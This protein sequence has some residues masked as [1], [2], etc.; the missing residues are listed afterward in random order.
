MTEAPELSG[1]QSRGGLLAALFALPA[2]L[3]VV[4]A[5]SGPIVSGDLF[6]HLSTGHWILDN[7]ALPETDP[8]SH[9]AGDKDWTL[10]EYGS[11]VL[12]ALLEDAGG[13]TLLRIVGAVLGAAVCAAA[14]FV[15]RRRLSPAWS[16]AATALFALLFALKWELRPHLLSVFFFLRLTHLLFPMRREADPGPRV[17]GERPWS[18]G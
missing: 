2:V 6:W 12:F 1:T 5:L 17:W 14:F 16:A 11:Q 8:F 7:A 3:V 13:M 10:E 18:G 9:T 15:A 4:F